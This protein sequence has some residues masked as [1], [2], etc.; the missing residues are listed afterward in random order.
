MWSEPAG[1]KKGS[2]RFLRFTKKVTR[3]LFSCAILGLTF[4]RRRPAAYSG[5]YETMHKQRIRLYAWTAAA[6]MLAA[7]PARAQY[8]QRPLNDL[9]TGQKYHIEAQAGFWTPTSDLT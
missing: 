4:P 7:S 2:G 8:I 6:L 1:K 5:D 3:P 9:A